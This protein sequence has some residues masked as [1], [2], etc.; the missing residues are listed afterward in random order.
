MFHACLP[1]SSQSLLFFRDLRCRFVDSDVSLHSQFPVIFPSSFATV[2]LNL[3][4]LRSTVTT[5]L[6]STVLT[7]IS[8]WRA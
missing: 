8:G 6:C 3:R 7:A 5:R 1:L 2:R 4:A